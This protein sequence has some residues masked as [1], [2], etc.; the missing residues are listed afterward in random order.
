[1]RYPQPYHL[2]WMNDSSEMRAK[3]LAL[4]SFQIW[5]FKDAVLCDIAPM[6]AC[7]ILL[8]RTWQF[9]REVMSKG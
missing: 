6:T 5:D 2:Q 1:M 8:D 7:H 4:V 3:K 9:N